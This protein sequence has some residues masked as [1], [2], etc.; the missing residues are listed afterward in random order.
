MNAPDKNFGAT[1]EVASAE[2]ELR[3]AQEALEAA[4]ARLAQLKE[5]HPPIEPGGED[6]NEDAEDAA[7]D[8]AEVHAVEDESA[9]EAAE[10]ATAVT[11]VIEVE[12]VSCKVEEVEVVDGE[13]A[14][15]PAAD[16][17]GAVEASDESEPDK[18]EAVP[19]WIPYSLSL[20]HI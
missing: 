3:A 8:A 16:E 20:I 10:D 15:A 11:A 9:E 7:E 2:A 12:P 4:K 6:A 5:E 18:P 1:D 17:E 19:D 14:P 13:E